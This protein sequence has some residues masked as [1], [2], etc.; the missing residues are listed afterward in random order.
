MT[1]MFV[2]ILKSVFTLQYLPGSAMTPTREAT[3]SP[4][5][6][7]IAKP[8]MSSLFSQTRNGPIGFLSGSLKLSMRPL[9][10]MILVASSFWHGF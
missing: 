8:G 1:A 7:V 2:Y 4:K 9:Q 5:L 10:F 6:L 3:S